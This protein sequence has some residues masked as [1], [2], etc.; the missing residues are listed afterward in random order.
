MQVP[1]SI[2]TLCPECDEG[3][4]HKTLK[5]RVLGK[6]ALQLVLKCSE[7]GLVTEQRL[8]LSGKTEIRMII[9]RGRDSEKATVEFPSDWAMAI[10]DEFMHGDERLKVTGIEVGGRR[11]RSATL[12][13]IQTLWTM[14]FDTVR[15]KVSVNRGGRTRSLEIAVDPDEEFEAGTEIEIDGRRMLAHSIKTRDKK[16]RKGKATAREIVRLYCTDQSPRRKRGT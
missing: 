3:T 16:F 10:D 8:E 14:N 15:L 9:S 12:R 11:V 7:C 6:K 2:H 1:P 5:G 13:D 4:L